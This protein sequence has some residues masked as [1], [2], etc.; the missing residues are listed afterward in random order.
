M[1]KSVAIVGAGS[2]GTNAAVRLR[3]LLGDA[4]L[5]VYER[6]PHAGGRAWD[7]D[8]AGTTVEIGGTVLHSTGRHIMDL[9]K[10]TGAE[11]GMYTAGIQEA[12]KTY[13][14]WTGQGF[15]VKCRETLLSMAL[16]IIRH[17]GPFSALRVTTAVQKVAEKWTGI[18]ALQDAGVTFESPQ[19]LLRALGL[20][21]ETHVT[22]GD[23]LRGHKVNQRMV[24]DIVV[25]IVHNMYNQ[26]GELNA[27]AGQVGLA[28][29]GL[30]G[31]YLFSIKG[32]NKTLFSRALD[33]VGAQVKLDTAVTRIAPTGGQWTVETAAGKQVYDAVVLAAPLAMAN[34]DLVID[35]P[36]PVHPYQTVNTTL[37]VGE[38]DPEYFGLAPGSALPGNFFVAD[39]AGQPFM[40]LGIT[41]ISPQYNQKIYK[42][43]SAET[44]LTDDF[45]AKVFKK[46]DAVHRHV[47]RGAYP[48]LPPNI[49]HVPFRLADGLYYAC[50]F[51]T[52]A[53]AIE[54]EA[55]GGHNAGTLAA[56]YLG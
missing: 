55:V 3:E 16:G 7:V 37:V 30:A 33:K 35:N 41:G 29:A 18:Y 28:G 43:F 26:G 46:A 1:G 10:L 22:L 24:D 23:G 15:V 39:S 14:F 17:V 11:E 52:A 21:D 42:L 49:D 50:A 44:E 36:P 5:T 25:P 47:W 2:A 56:N 31:G 38:L 20:E 27:L 13:W 9:M 4:E 12:D 48:K 51:E 6:G 54:V 53:G 32:G 45:L 19:Q 40:S 8:F 34:L